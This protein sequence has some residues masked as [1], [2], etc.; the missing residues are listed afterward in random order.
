VAGYYL[1]GTGYDDMAVLWVAQFL[2]MISSD[3]AQLETLRNI[4]REFLADAGAAGKKRRI[5]DISGNV[6]GVSASPFEVV[7]TTI[8]STDRPCRTYRY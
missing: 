7:C 4:T 3:M 1:N 8:S 6:G 2:S 5:V